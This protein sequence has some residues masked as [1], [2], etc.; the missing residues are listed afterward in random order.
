M[1][2]VCCV[3]FIVPFLPALP[4]HEDKNWVHCR[5]GPDTHGCKLEVAM[6]TLNVHAHTME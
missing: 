2:G 6:G 1:Q 5:A 3:F 4:T